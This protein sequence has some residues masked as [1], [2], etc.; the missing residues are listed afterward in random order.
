MAKID[1]KAEKKQDSVIALN[2]KARHDYHIDQRY[3]AG[4]E[5]YGWEVKSMRAGQARITESHVLLQNGEAFLFG[6]TVTP[7]P[8]ASAHVKADPARHRKLLLHR[9]ELD[10]L[11]SAVQRKSYTLVPL[12]L[13]WRRGRI[14]LEIGLARGKR[15]YDKRQE[16][17]QRDW[18]RE[19]QRLIRKF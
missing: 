11:G 14:K 3:E 8:S 19:Q 1:K 17:K 6:A 18:Q 12:A 15:V 2:R 4:L 13:Y 9:R 7:L 16:V 5:L 10:R